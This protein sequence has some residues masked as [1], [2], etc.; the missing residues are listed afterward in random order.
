MIGLGRTDRHFL[1]NWW[2]TIDRWLLLGILSLM[3]I[4]FVMTFAAS[5]VIAQRLEIDT[6]YFAYRQIVFLAAAL[7]LMVLVSLL[8]P[9]QIRRLALGLGV[10]AL[11]G[12]LLTLTMGAE[13]NGSTRWLRVMGFSLQPSEFLK[14]CFVVTVAWCFAMQNTRLDVSGRLIGLV[15]LVLVCAL[16]SWQ[17]DIGQMILLTVVWTAMF[18]IAGGSYLFLSAMTVAGLCLTVFLY[19]SFAHFRFRVDRFLDPS[20]GG[21]YQTDK[22]LEAFRNGGL[23]GTG[24]GDGKIKHVL[25]DG[26]T[27]YVFAVAAEEFGL[28]VGLIIIFIFAAIVFRSLLSLRDSREHWIQLS[29]MGLIILFGLQTIIN[30]AV[31]LNLMPP[32]G[33]T[34]P[35]ISYG[36]SS[37]LS[38]A[39][40][41]GM[42]L[43]L[44]RHSSGNKRIITDGCADEIPLHK[45]LN[46]KGG[47]V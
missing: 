24:P 42:M 46:L 15:L 47:M 2:W 41:M 44:T 29:G 40:T 4:G 45:T 17:P 11:G 8:N 5:P 10:A 33:M 19:Q 21:T 9:V 1:A 14:P 35:F 27:D 36:G 30:M 38:L 6:Y 31:N 18:F 23:F 25:P 32:K 7:V 16:L 12:V 22:A 37:L 20:L 28:V 26:H 34:L 43:S 13:I 3:L 39:L